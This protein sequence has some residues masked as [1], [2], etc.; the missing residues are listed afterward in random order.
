[1]SLIPGSISVQYTR[2]SL[3]LNRARESGVRLPAREFFVA[4]VILNT[5]LHG[6]QI[7]N[8]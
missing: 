7:F 6:T 8:T 5:S 1:M 3:E 4:T 2:L